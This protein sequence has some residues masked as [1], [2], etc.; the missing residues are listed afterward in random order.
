MMKKLIMICALLFSFPAMAA[1]SVSPKIAYGSHT[2]QIVQVY[3][4]DSCRNVSCPVVLWV[5]GGGWRN[6]DMTG[7]AAAPLFNSWTNQGIVMVGVNY[8]L[9]PEVVHPAHVEDVA[10]AINWTHKNIV[11]YGGD[12]QRIS[13]LGH[14]AG[15]HLVALVATNPTY[16]AAYGLSPA[17]LKNVFPID[18]ASFDLTDSRPLV[19]KMIEDAFGTDPDI[20]REASPIWQVHPKGQ[21]P[22]FII[23]A[24]QNRKDAV[25][26]SQQLETNLRQA[27]A[28]VELMTVHY[29]DLR[30]MKAHGQ[31]AK[32]LYDVNNSLTSKLIKRVKSN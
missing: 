21:Y 15:A 20:L 18:T 24:V 11:K 28:P 2:K 31:I 7:R 29:S 22:S 32:D 23:A 17:N 25:E 9:S 1:T 8:R 4:P 10:A 13:L 5:H 3:T 26:T 6:G 16:L 19:G 27:G 14:S 12:P 30:Q